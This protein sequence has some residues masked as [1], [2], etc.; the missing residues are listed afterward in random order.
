MQLQFKDMGYGFIL[1]P[2]GKAENSSW[3]ASYAG[4]EHKPKGKG[5]F[6][7]IINSII[8]YDVAT[9]NETALVIRGENQ[10]TSYF[11]LLGDFRKEFEIAAATGGL[12]SCKKLYDQKK[13]LYI[14]PRSE[15]FTGA[16]YH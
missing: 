12:T 16:T 15:D 6:E 5:F 2:E 4:A 13:V 1:A 8:G 7:S 11:I 14:S 10:A 3:Y 9:T